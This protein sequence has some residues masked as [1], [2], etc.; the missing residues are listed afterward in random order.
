ML[1]DDQGTYRIPRVAFASPDPTWCGLEDAF[2]ADLVFRS[3][4]EQLHLGGPHGAFAYVLHVSWVLRQAPD[5]GET[6]EG[7]APGRLALA[8]PVDDRGTLRRVG[9][10]G[11]RPARRRRTTVGGACRARRRGPPALSQLG[12]RDRH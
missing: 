11:G 10:A 12:G 1:G 8:R 9:E 3:A 7:R 2:R 4:P 5:L 6:H